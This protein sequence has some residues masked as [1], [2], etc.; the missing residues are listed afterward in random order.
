MTASAP[1]IATVT[2]NPAIDQTAQ[3]SDFAVDR[4]NRVEETQID[5]GG[6]GV[7]VASFL[8]HFDHDVVAT[9][10]IGA[11]NADVFDQLFARSG[12]HDRFVRL[13]GRTRTNVKVLDYS[14]NTVTDIN[15]PGL[16][17]KPSAFGKIRDMVTMLCEEGIEHVVLS[18]SLPAAAPSSIYADLIVSLKEKG[19]RVYLDTSGEALKKG[20][21]AAPHVIKPNLDELQTVCDTEF[22][23][24]F[25]IIEATRSLG[26]GGIEL[27]AVSMGESGALFVTQDN[28]LLAVPPVTPVKSTVGAGDAMVA[29]LVHSAVEGLELAAMAKLATGFALGALGDVG[30]HLPSQDQIR[31]LASEVTVQDLTD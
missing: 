30:P 14:Q 24:L 8:S 17:A 11:D 16:M 27:A 2:L 31:L 5:A 18:G 19:L 28:A 25:D 29:G 23:S 6:K 22:H 15:F 1:K 12:I 4:V 10:L 26:G 9:G 21:D 20:L 3:V 7:N 13:P